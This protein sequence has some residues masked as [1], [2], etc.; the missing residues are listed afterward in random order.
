MHDKNR[1][2]CPLPLYAGLDYASAARKACSLAVMPLVM[3]ASLGTRPGT[4]GMGNQV[5]SS[6]M[7]RALVS[8]AKE[9]KI[10]P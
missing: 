3:R 10:T 4:T 8:S 9:A 2:I 7:V 1:Q 5:L 6:S